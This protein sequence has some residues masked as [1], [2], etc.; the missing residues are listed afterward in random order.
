MTIAPLFSTL[1]FT[2]LAGLHFTW[3]IRGGSNLSL[4]VPTQGKTPVFRPTRTA[5][6]V[7]ALGL[8]AM[9]FVSLSALTGWLPPSWIHWGNAAIAVIFLLRTVGD[10]R[11]VGIFKRFRDTPFA[12]NDTRYYSPLCL[13][14]AV[15]AAVI[16]AQTGA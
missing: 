16:A 6:V 4:T 9:A 1:I 3:A 11:Y 12:R 13:L 8:L 5:T 15:S 2:V 7:V 10:F 14:L